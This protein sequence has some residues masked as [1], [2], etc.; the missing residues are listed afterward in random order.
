MKIAQLVAFLDLVLVTC[1]QMTDHRIRDWF[2]GQINQHKLS[3]L[4]FSGRHSNFDALTL[5]T[6]E[7]LDF[8]FTAE[9]S[10][11]INLETI[12]IKRLD[13]VDKITLIT[14]ELH[15]EAGEEELVQQAIEKLESIVTPGDRSVPF[16]LSQARFS[17]V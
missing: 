12:E 11:F 14:G 13:A 16:P 4:R 1:A 10:E 2:T 6:Q 3:P 5:T 15:D 8:D 9:C 7:I 17:R